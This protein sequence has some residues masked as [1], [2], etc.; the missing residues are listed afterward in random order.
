MV[1]DL[2]TSNQWIL[3]LLSEVMTRIWIFILYQSISTQSSCLSQA[4]NINFT[5]E[6]SDVTN[7]TQE[8]T[9]VASH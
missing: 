9:L 6:K 2:G 8:S 5:V 3:N 1:N 4:Y 7:L